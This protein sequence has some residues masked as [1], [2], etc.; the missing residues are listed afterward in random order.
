MTFGNTT[1]KLRGTYFDTPDPAGT[2]VFAVDHRVL[3]PE[4]YKAACSHVPP[5]DERAEDVPVSW[6]K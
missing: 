3:T 5:G 4:E 6:V 1:W 2:A